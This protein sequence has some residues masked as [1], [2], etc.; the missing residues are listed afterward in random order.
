[1]Y[2]LI[3][4]QQQVLSIYNLVQEQALPLDIATVFNAIN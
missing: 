1:M 3:L 4:H 2:D